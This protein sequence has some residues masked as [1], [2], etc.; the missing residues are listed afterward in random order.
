[1][2]WLAGYIPRRRG[3]RRGGK[4]GEKKGM[5]GFPAKKRNSPNTEECR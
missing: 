3:K 2:T 5:E 4:M 1:L